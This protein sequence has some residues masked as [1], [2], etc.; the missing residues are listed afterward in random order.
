MMTRHVIFTGGG[1]GGHLFPGL[2]V[3]S[4]LAKLASGVRITFVGSGAAFERQLVEAA[5]FHYHSLAC[6]PLPRSPWQALQFVGSNARGCWQAGRLLHHLRASAVV[7]LGGFASVPLARAAIAADV[8]LVLLEQNAW[9]GRAT[10]WLAPGASLICTAFDLPSDSLRAGG[11]V[12]TTGNPIRPGFTASRSDQP[13]LVILGGSQGARPLNQFVPRALRKISRLLRGWEI[14]HQSGPRDCQ[15]TKAF[16]SR[17]GINARVTPFIGE[18]PELLSG[19]DLAISRAGGTI[20]AE[21]AAA[22]V[23]ALLIPYPHAAD[24]HQRRN[25]QVFVDC[26]GCVLVDQ[27]PPDRRFDDRLAAALAPLLAN[28]ALR[29]RMSN[30]MQHRARP[31]AAWRVATLIAE[32]AQPLQRAFAA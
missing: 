20:L 15:A 18:M 14:V 1:T 8:P 23:P 21:L 32:I 11:P 5:G 17:L 6:R 7:G 22:G 31:D 24:D 29:G 9:P 16:Y 4:E 12:R 26:G 10:R 30:A 13:R 27:N 3:A 2:P 19:G 28:R 25:A